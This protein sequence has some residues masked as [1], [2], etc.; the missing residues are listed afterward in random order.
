MAGY[1]QVP[2]KT[3][4]LIIPVN[5]I[6]ACISHPFG[7]WLAQSQNPKVVLGIVGM[8]GPVAL[9]IGSLMPNFYLWWIFYIIAYAVVDGLTYMSTVKHGWDWWPDKPGFASGIIIS[10]FGLSGLIWN[11]VSLELVNP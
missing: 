8:C 3:T 7:S 10:G 1:Y 4:E 6:V 11:F 2:V 9:I 5:F